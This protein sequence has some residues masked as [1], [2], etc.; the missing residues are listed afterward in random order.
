M[1]ETQKKIMSYIRRYIKRKGFPPTQREIAKY[2][3]RSVST[4]NEALGVLEGMGKLGRNTQRQANT[5][6][7]RTIQLPG[8]GS[9]SRRIDL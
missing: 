7:G 1:T 2:T 4:I 3:G 8:A 5:G 6:K 9:N